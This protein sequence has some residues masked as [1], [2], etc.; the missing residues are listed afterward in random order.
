EVCDIDGFNVARI[1][2]H[3]TLEN[4]VDMVVPELQKR[5]LYK[6]EYRPGTFREKLFGHGRIAS[7]HLA[8][9]FSR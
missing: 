6:T 4:F 9:S 5:G 2:A 3:E 7:D 1:V 8:G